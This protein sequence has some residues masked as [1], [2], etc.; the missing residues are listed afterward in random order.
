MNLPLPRSLTTP[1][2]LAGAGLLSADDVPGLAPVAARYAIGITPG[3]ASLSQSHP[4]IARQFVPTTGELVVD[5]AERADP[6]GDHAHAP[7]KG[8]VHR[9]P[10]R[11]LLMPTL[12]C[13]VYCRFCFRRETVGE[14]GVLSPADMQAALA[15]I[16]A[17]PAVW[18]VILTG[19]DPLTLSARRIGEIVTTLNEIPHVKVIRIH[20]RVP[21][22]AP[23]RID[24]A[25]IAVLRA[26]AKP[27]YMAIHCNHALE[28]TADVR[29]ACGRLTGAGIPLLAHSVLL[30]GV[31]DTVEA[32]EDLMR[33]LVEARV[34]PYY[35]SQLDLAP[36]TS[37]FRVPLAEGQRL[38]AA[39]RGRV[40][41]IA[42]PTYILDIPG[43]A[44]KVPVG[45]VY[46]SPEGDGTF[47]VRDPRGGIHS[48]TPEASEPAK[49]S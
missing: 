17:T 16:R 5:P 34:R 24:D 30:K 37:H 7:V 26:S 35:L 22:A 8:I 18:E 2:A 9:Y 29:A 40:S 25:L 46:L 32:L 33:G 19:G 44:G 3:L 23:E 11:L 4:A 41:G 21:V 43:G 42:L 14:S 48:Y 39:L 36:G 49:T 1:A 45:Q 28:L 47:L 12:S 31:N 6:I 20:T 38:T 13:A 10:D 27:V 15:Y